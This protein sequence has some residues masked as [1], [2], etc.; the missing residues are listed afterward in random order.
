[1]DKQMEVS[2]VSLAG[3]IALQYLRQTKPT[4]FFEQAEYALREAKKIVDGVFP[5]RGR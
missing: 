4:R 3:Q 1:M 5:D 2:K